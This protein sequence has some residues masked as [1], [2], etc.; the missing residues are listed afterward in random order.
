MERTI[1]PEDLKE[2]LDDAE[3]LCYNRRRAGVS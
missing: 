3:R 2:Q 1:K